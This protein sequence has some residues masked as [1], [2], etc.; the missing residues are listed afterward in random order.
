MW[1]SARVNMHARACA[2]RSGYMRTKRT[3]GE[4]GTCDAP[5]GE[6]GLVSSRASPSLR[7][8]LLPA[9]IG[10]YFF[11]AEREERDGLRIRLPGVIDVEYVYS[12]KTHFLS[13]SRSFFFM[14]LL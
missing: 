5:R 2:T 6:G 4:G 8:R 11:A 13:L 12:Y 1:H 3:E 10:N 9:F 7:S 14:V